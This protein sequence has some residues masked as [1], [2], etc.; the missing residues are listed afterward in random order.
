MKND[1]IVN[2]FDTI[3]PD[4]DVKNR[5]FEKA[6]KKPRR[7]RPV[8]RAAISFAAAAA[9]I[10]LMVLGSI[11]LSSR[12]NS[13]FAIKAYA[14]EVREDGSIQLRE[15][16][17]VD[18]QPEYAGFYMDE[19][20]NTVYVSVGLRCEGEN[21]ESV[22]F[23]TNNGFFAKQYI[24]K[25][26][27]ISTVGVPT[28]YMGNQMVLS[29]TDF[30]NSGNT[31]TLDKDAMGNYLLF[32]G[33]ENTEALQFPDISQ[34]IFVHAI[35]TFINGKTEERDVTIDM[36]KTQIAGI[37]NPNA[38]ET[39]RMREES[40]TYQELLRDIPLN[41]CEVVAG[42][43]KTLTYGDTYEYS[44]GDDLT[45]GTAY[46]P[47]TEESID[48]AVDEGMFDEN[49]IFRIGS[50]LYETRYENQGSSRYIAVIERNGDGTFTGMVYEVSEQLILDN[51][52]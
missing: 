10:C 22:E 34:K 48:A 26:S 38:K 36:S 40:E 44:F 19:E 27:E 18:A 45:S 39:A 3:Q 32:W 12:D 17:I 6:L 49:G 28:A 52:K 14:M 46:F 24:G 47:I 33:L 20:T 11:V 16:D 2:A 4:E 9:V 13:M 29:G 25:L 37:I 23:S 43:V 8:H 7:K 42:S 35:A 5:V 51:M 50:N 31:M 30:D 41:Q 1:K 21:I 15:V